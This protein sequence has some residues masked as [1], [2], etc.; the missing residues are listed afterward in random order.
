MI[1]S[2]SFIFL[3]FEKF[4]G[5]I[6]G[7]ELFRGCLNGYLWSVAPLWFDPS[8]LATGESVK[9]SWVFCILSE[10]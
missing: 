1:F 3:S 5:K 2:V 9:R 7:V 6:L 4:F 10:D 8:I